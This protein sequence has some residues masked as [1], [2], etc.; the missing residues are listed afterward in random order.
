MGD[1]TFFGLFGPAP[2]GCIIDLYSRL[3]AW[4]MKERPN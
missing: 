3:V 2:G 4:L 1:V